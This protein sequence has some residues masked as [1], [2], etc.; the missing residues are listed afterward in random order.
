MGFVGILIAI[1]LTLTGFV[2]IDTSLEIA[3]AVGYNSHSPIKITSNSEFTRDNGVVSGSGTDDDPY[4]I[5]GWEIDAQNGLYGIWIKD[6][7]A[8][9]VIRNCLI[10]GA[11]DNSGEPW[12]S[13]IAIVNARNGIVENVICHNNSYGIRIITEG[14]IV[15]NS[16]FHNNN[17]RGISIESPN[18]LV[19]NNELYNNGDNIVLWN[20]G[21]R[22]IK[23][24]IKDGGRGIYLSSSNDNIIANNTISNCNDDGIYLYDRCYRN[25]IENNSIESIKN[26]YCGIDVYWY[27]DNNIIIHNY[28]ANNSGYGV[29]LSFSSYNIVYK[30]IFIQNNGAGNRFDS[31]HVQAYDNADNYWNSSGIGNYWYDWANNNN[32]NDR[33]DDGIVDWAYT[34]DGGA[35]DNY[36]VKS[37]E[38]YP[39]RSLEAEGGN[40][41]VRLSWNPPSFPG[42]SPITEYKIYRDNNLLITLPSNQNHYNDTGVSNGRSYS[43][44]ITA[45]NRYG[46]SS[47][48][49]M[50]SATPFGRPSTPRNLRATAGDGLVNLSW[51]PPTDDGGYPIVNYKVYRGT[52]SGGETFHVMVGNITHHIDAGLSNGQTY[53]YRISAVNSNGIEGELSTEVN[54]TPGRVPSA[55]LNLEAILSDNRVYLTWS[56]PIDNG[57]LPI[58]GY[59]IY[60]GNA[61]G[62][63]ELIASVGTINYYN[64]ST[65]EKGKT[66]YYQVSAINSRGESERSNEVSVT[67]KAAE[68]STPGF[69]MILLIIGILL[70]SIITRG[71]RRC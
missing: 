36:P 4:I 68:K 2:V 34:I 14:T 8:H 25:I 5:E 28:I 42:L 63:E 61:S 10:H 59:N 38:P 15:R 65:V 54:A 62:E 21:T 56:T 18:V 48:S 57:G 13:G 29:Y 67:L 23:N 32:T 35:K 44:Y 7:D 53:Y 27:S 24:K 58:T 45:I 30:N 1:S 22:I 47:R 64:D 20:S 41:Y 69:E 46:E 43:Y 52:T 66:Y 55:P 60:R 40:R 3:R 6:T 49:N 9:F 70:V 19:E 39:P 17:V 12:G 26:G 50:V 16:K 33:D 31:S 37:K 71:R 51:D 11:T